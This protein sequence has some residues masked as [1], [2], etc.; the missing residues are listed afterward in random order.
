MLAK[1]KNPIVK[2]IHKFGPTKV[3]AKNPVLSIILSLRNEFNTIQNI[4]K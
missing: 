1:R 3:I 2:Y 4:R